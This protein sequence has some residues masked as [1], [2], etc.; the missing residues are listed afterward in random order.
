[1]PIVVCGV[2]KREFG[3][4]ALPSHVRAILVKREFAPT[5]EIALRLHPEAKRITVVAGTSEFDTRLLDLAKNEFRAFEGRLAFSYL[6]GLP[7]RDILTQ[8]SELPPETIVLFTTFFQDGAGAAF[9]PHDVV[10]RVS[11]AARAP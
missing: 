2:D 1:T 4:R 9:V 10:Q 7:L 8:L 6:T 3:D 5:L 11:E